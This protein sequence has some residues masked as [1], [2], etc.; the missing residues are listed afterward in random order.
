[1]NGHFFIYNGKYFEHGEPVISTGNRALRYADGLFETMRMYHDTIL[2][3]DLHFERLFS[4]MK[5][6][7]IEIPKLYSKEFFVTAANALLKKNS[8]GE[9]ARI[10]L[11]IFRNGC[12]GI[13]DSENNSPGYIIETWP[14]PEKI[15]LNENGLVV[16]IF[17][18]AKKSCDTFSNL[19]S[20][21][22]LSSVMAGLFVKK[23]KL[24]DAILLNVFGRVCESAISNIFVVKDKNIFT[25]S[26]SEGCVAGTTRR[27]I[28]ENFSHELLMI[29]EK[30]LHVDD[31][32]E[33]DEIFLT[34]AIHPVRWIQNFR[35]RNY[36]NRVANEVYDW[37]IRNILK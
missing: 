22:Y 25:P 21:N 8:H 10:R 11:M 1:M 37:V 36:G 5:V 6:L 16:D 28:L 2:N 13:F 4:G 35:G 7:Q 12:G 14:L 24:N 33:A 18:D 29:N 3:V 17:T 32:L 27:W 19:K 34:N 20:N 15:K 30:E 26:L 23:N 9:N 31:L